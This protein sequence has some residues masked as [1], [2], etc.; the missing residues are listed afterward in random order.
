MLATSRPCRCAPARGN[1]NWNDY[2]AGSPCQYALDHEG[3]GAH[4][5]QVWRDSPCLLSLRW[6]L[7]SGS[8]ACGA[9]STTSSGRPLC[10]SVAR[11]RLP[12]AGGV[13]YPIYENEKAWNGNLHRL[14]PLADHH[15]EMQ[16]FASN[17]DANY[18]GWINR[19]A[20]VDRHRRLSVMTSYLAE[21]RPVIA[22]PEG[23][24]AQLE[25]GNRVLGSG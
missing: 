20:R 21:S 12:A 1:R 18:L 6:S 15:R 5:L 13:R 9:R 3:S 16:P 23:C 22:L 10:I 7:A 4:V 19:L 25:W 11:S 2:I 17:L 24:T 8:T 14:E